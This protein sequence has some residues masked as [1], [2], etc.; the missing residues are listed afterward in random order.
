MILNEQIKAN[1]QI[2]SEYKIRKEKYQR[3]NDQKH[4]DANFEIAIDAVKDTICCFQY[5][6]EESD[7]KESQEELNNLSNLLVIC[8]D[9]VNTGYVNATDTAKINSLN[10]LYKEELQEEWKEYYVNTTSAIEEIL[11]V[12][13]NFTGSETKSL[14]NDI[15]NASELK[16]D[17]YVIG[18]MMLAIEKSNEIIEQ[19][20]LNDT[21]IDFLKKMLNNTASLDDLNDEVEEWIMKENMKRKIKLSFL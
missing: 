1:T 8:K 4:L 5:A 14:I 21:I 13:Q 6:K 19:L 9:M 16:N 10:R 12:T 15:K 17:R 20:E 3:A 11:N 2:V 18:K 7:F